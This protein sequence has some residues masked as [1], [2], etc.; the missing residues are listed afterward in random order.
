MLKLVYQAASQPETTSGSP[1]YAMSDALTIR[2]RELSALL[3]LQFKFTEA[4][5]FRDF[6]MIGMSD[7]SGS[8][9]GALVFM[10]NADEPPL[11]RISKQERGGEIVWVCETRDMADVYGKLYDSCIEKSQLVFIEQVASLFHKMLA[12]E[13]T[14]QPAEQPSAK[15]HLTVIK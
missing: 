14:P 6:G 15:P 2:G 12:Q 3:S 9:I 7:Q 1:F 8:A 4:G 13:Q 5:L 10:Q 11:A